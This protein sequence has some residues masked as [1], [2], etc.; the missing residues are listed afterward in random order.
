[1][2]HFNAPEMPKGPGAHAVKVDATGTIYCS[3]WVPMTPDGQIITEIKEATKRCIT[4]LGYSLK[5]AGSSWEKVVKVNIF[6]ADINDFAALNEVYIPLMPNPAPAR[7][8]I[9]A[10]ALPKGS[11]VEMEC[12]AIV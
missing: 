12:I 10:G 11:I 3:G 2:Q 1:M 8:C 6:L 4:N 5:A 9:Q 7:T